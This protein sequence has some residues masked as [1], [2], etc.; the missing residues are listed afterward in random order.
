MFIIFAFMCTDSVAESRLSVL[1]YQSELLTYS[2]L[3]KSRRLLSVKGQREL[4]G[5]KLVH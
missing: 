3:L 1:S 2:S 4:R 5:V